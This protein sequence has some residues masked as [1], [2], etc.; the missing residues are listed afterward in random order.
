[1]SFLLPRRMQGGFQT[2][3]KLL[4]PPRCIG[5]DERVETEFGLCG[6]CWRGTPFIGGTVCDACGAP[7]IGPADGFRLECDDCMANPR[8]WRQG[9]SVLLYQDRARQLVL[10]LKHG[11]RTD[12]ARPAGGWLARAAAPLL[13]DMPL[14]APVP[15]HWQRLLKRR[16]NQSALLSRSL[17]R[18]TGLDHCPDLLLRP[19]RTDPLEGK[20]AAQRFAMLEQAVRLH[21]R[22]SGR[23]RGRSVLLVDDVMTS[24]ATLS[25][26]TRACLSGGAIDVFVLTLARVI[27]DD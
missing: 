19:A 5:C 17:A 1:M 15:L 12:I 25:A 21:P 16:Y 13:A 6:P 14:I 9:R 22:R 23:L 18:V 3:L 8:P 20:T 27:K 7:L 26:C 11:D 24:G 10:A 2:A 4:Y